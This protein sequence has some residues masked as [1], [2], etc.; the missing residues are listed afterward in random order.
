MDSLNR[1]LAI[2][3]STEHCS[4]ALCV[5]GQRL[6]DVCE[7]P[8]S[9]ANVLLPMVDNILSEAG[10]SLPEL[11][12]I[13]VSLGPGSFTGIRI[14]IGVVQ[15]LA[16]GA[17]L[18]VI[19][20]SSLETLA[21]RA[22][23]STQSTSGKPDHGT[24]ILPCLDARMDEVYWAAYAY[25]IDTISEVLRPRVSSIDELN[26][27][28]QQLDTSCIGAGHGW[29]VPNAVNVEV[30]DSKLLPNAAAMLDLVEQY[31]YHQKP[32]SEF[33]AA[34]IEPLYLRNEVTWVKRTR[35][36]KEQPI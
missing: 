31:Q 16:Y 4:V 2:D 27:Y 29:L 28:I 11:Q 14:G 3:A 6:A 12:A 20:F 7:T 5:D 30:C 35:I 32:L 33:S 22:I 19:G 9:H 18:P 13:V 36:R 23:A 10:I 25:G 8:K 1:I 21:W 17:K 34:S 26:T 15:G 24:I